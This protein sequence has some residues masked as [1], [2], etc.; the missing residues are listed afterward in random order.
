[1][2]AREEVVSAANKILTAC[3]ALPARSDIVIFADETTLPTAHILL[4]AAVQL[5]LCPTLIC[6]PLQTQLLLR[7]HGLK[8]HHS[9]L[10]DDAVA[11]LVCLN[12]TPACL[13]FRDR[14][15]QAA[16]NAGCK[17]AHMPGIT[18]ATLLLA[19]VDYPTLI[20]HCELFA[21]ALAKGRNL[22]IITQDQAGVEHRLAVP[23]DPWRRLP[24]ISDSII[25]KRSW[26][27]IPPGETYIAPPEG[28]ATGSIVIDG[29]LPGYVI[30]P[31]EEI[32]LHFAQ[33]RLV[34]WSP[35]TT[36]AARH[37]LQTQIELARAAGDENWSNLA[38]VGLGVNPRVE[39]LSG[40]PL[41]DEKKYGS[42]HIALGDSTD[43]GG[44]ISAKIHCDLVTL[45]PKVL[46]DGKVIIDRNRIVIA[47]DAWYEDHHHLRV[48][49]W[50]QPHLPIA[51]T[52]TD[53]QVDETFH[54]HRLWDTSAGR[55]CSVQV[56]V[57]A[58][59][60]LAST[61]YQFLQDRSVPISIAELAMQLPN[62]DLH[63]LLQLTYL[64][65]QYELIKVQQNGTAK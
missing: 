31:G 43:M 18:P 20:A 35:I 61:V 3:L 33:G 12:G 48:P 51:C 32:I 40:S 25:Q 19:N 42:L 59:S 10:L 16:L 41:L 56:G 5:A 47:P 13:P 50:W 27:N 37:L 28:Q 36:R 38:E 30:E 22:E 8:S 64:L 49:E 65:Q 29:S 26:G 23:L 46:V 55:V 34:K 45:S 14:V 53:V 17:V 1:M 4:E 2:E 52:A 9:A 39:K 44:Q 63:Q 11:V 60:T 57:A 7:E 24:I 21:L 58:T 54:L 62:A 15:R 6:Y